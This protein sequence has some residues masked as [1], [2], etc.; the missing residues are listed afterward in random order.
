MDLDGGDDSAENCAR[1]IANRADY[2]SY[3][4]LVDSDSIVDM[5]PWEYEAWQDSETNPWAVGISA[6]LSASR[7]LEVPPARREGFYRNMAH[8]A[9]D[10]VRHMASKGVTVPLRRI[11]GHEA[12]SGVAG[13]CAHGD[14]GVSRSDPGTQFDWE[15]FFRYTKQALDGALANTGTTIY[16]PE[17]EVTPEQYSELYNMLHRTLALAESFEDVLTDP[18]TGY[19]GHAAKLTL[20]GGVPSKYVKGDAP[21]EASIWEELDGGV[22]RPVSYAE[23][24]IAFAA[25]ETFR[26]VDQKLIDEAQKAS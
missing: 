2:G 17:A 18:V 26:L 25:G 19:I 3:H 6:A 16:S 7:W 13:F 4:R 9:A 5:L 8:C 10:F 20:K 22:L 12:R 15:T 11:S 21:G 23:W 24:K 1:F 14:S